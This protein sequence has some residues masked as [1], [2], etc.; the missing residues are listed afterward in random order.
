MRDALERFLSEWNTSQRT[1]E[2]MFVRQLAAAEA[3]SACTFALLTQRSFSYQARS[4]TD[5]IVFHVVI[6]LLT[7][8]LKT[9]VAICTLCRAG[10]GE[11][12][13]ALLRMFYE[14]VSLIEFILSDDPPLRVAQYL[15]HV[16]HRDLSSLEE[17]GASPGQEGRVSSERL[18]AARR[19]RDTWA[20]RLPEG[21][22]FKKHWSGFNTFKEMQLHF[23]N[24]ETYHGFYRLASALIHG[25]DALQ[26]VHI[27]PDFKVTMNLLPG[28]KYVSS[29]LGS[30]PALL[31]LATSQ[32][33]RY[34]GL[35]HATDL[36]EVKPASIQEFQSGT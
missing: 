1:T 23:G 11:E 21:T 31:W 24:S 25:S 22:R 20:K 15:A 9:H 2:Q 28:D 27:G 13:T 35:G 6:S 12:A 18:D 10:L 16:A 34:F 3:V 26:H 33:D 5:R 17:V 36:A 8:S 32:I 14:T 30:A 29:A 19:E 4:G 7:K